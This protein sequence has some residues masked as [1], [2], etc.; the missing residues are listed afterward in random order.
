ML[1]RRDCWKF[2]VPEL[3]EVET[4]AR[5]LYPHIHGCVFASAELLRA[6]S[7]HPLSFSLDLLKDK[8]IIDVTRRGKLLILNLDAREN[9][10]V[11]MLIFHLRMTG[12]LFTASANREQGKH[13]RCKFNLLKESGEPLQLFFDDARTFGQILASNPARLQDWEFWRELGPEP[14]T[15]QPEELAPRLKGKRALKTALL[16]QKV[17]AGIGNIYADESLFMAGLLPDRPADSLKDS[18]VEKL[19]KAVQHILNLSISQCGSSIRDYRDA[20]GN[21]GSFQNSFSVYGKG[22]QNCP[23]CGNILQKTR[24]GGRATVFCPVCQK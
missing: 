7:L 14:L 15:L 9:S 2:I 11:S 20:D 17:I 13:T 10:D 23:K 6:Q 5:S 16:D 21:A 18:E 1:P 8:K 24:L 12:R 4:V 19:L 22:G 3:P